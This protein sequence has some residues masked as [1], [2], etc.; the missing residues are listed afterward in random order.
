LVE[1]SSRLTS[2]LTETAVMEMAGA[3]SFARGVAYQRDGRVNLGAVSGE[4]ATAVVRGTVPYETALWVADGELAWS[5]S[6]PVGDGG[7]FCK[8]CVAV[9]LSIGSVGDTD[10]ELGE[11]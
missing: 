8:H 2:F 6:C 4:R 7:D 5:C 10:R 11:P 1:S 9:A 3:R